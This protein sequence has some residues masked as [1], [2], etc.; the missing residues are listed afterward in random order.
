MVQNDVGIR[1]LHNHPKALSAAA[2]SVIPVEAGEEQ[3][4]DL[5]DCADEWK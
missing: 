3:G 1:V 4:F 2:E 5:D